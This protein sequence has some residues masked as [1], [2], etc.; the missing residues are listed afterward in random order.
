MTKKKHPLSSITDFVYESGIL[1]RTPRSGLWLLGTGTQSVAE[2]TSRTIFIGY[3]LAHLNGKAD[4]NKIVLMCL[5]H[6]LGEARTSDLNYM[7]QRYGRLAEDHAI[8]DIAKSVPFGPEI[9]ALYQEMH[10]R[11]TPEARLAKDADN[12]EWLAIMREQEHIGNTKAKAWAQN[13]F[14]RLKTPEGKSIGKRLLATS[15]DHW[16][17]DVNDPWFVDRKEKDRRWKR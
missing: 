17:L 10:A 2:H 3:A 6:D 7:H 15:P 8:E 16:W 1:A 12:L 14:K 9:K 5:F 13:A 4:R 11:V